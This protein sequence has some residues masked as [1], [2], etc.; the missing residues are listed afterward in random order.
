MPQ[1]QVT[2]DVESQRE[3][4]HLRPHQALPEHLPVHVPGRRHNHPRERRR[5]SSSSEHFVGENFQPS[6]DFL[7]PRL[8]GAKEERSGSG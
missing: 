8:E 5:S 4:T 7:W 2:M 1:A 3:T 6:H